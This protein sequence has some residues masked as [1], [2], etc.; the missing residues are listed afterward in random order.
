MWDSIGG[1]RDAKSAAEPWPGSDCWT[2]LQ[3]LNNATKRCQPWP[4]LSWLVRE[5]LL[6]GHLTVPDPSGA[7]LSTD[8]LSFS[9]RDE[10]QFFLLSRLLCKDGKPQSRALGLQEA[11][12]TSLPLHSGAGWWDRRAALLS[13]CHL[14]FY[15]QLASSCSAL[16]CSPNH[17]KLPVPIQSPVAWCSTSLEGS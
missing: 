12:C 16:L 11:S 7:A 9:H 6:Q 2:P 14:C 1:T 8:D 4:S 10:E 13:L 5:P 15:T 17:S 3:V